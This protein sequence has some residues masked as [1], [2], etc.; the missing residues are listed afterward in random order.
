PVRLGQRGQDA[1]DVGEG[2]TAPRLQPRLAQ[3]DVGER[4]L[5]N[6]TPRLGPAE[7]LFDDYA[8]GVQGLDVSAGAFAFGPKTVEVGRGY[9]CEPRDALSGQELDEAREDAGVLDQRLRRPALRFQIG[10]IVVHRLAN[11][12]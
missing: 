5:G 9:L 1:I 2:W 10:Q 6:Q 3:L 12:D 4:V 8:L 11:G 7:H